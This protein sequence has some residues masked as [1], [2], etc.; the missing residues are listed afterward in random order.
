ML[1][2]RCIVS[3][4]RK[5]W[6]WLKHRF[7]D[8][9][10]DRTA[11]LY[12]AAFRDFVVVEV[13]R[14]IDRQPGFKP[15]PRRWVIER[16]LGWLIPWRRLVHD[17]EQKIENSEAF[18]HLALASL[19]LRRIAH[20]SILKQAL[21]SWQKSEKGTRRRPLRWPEQRPNPPSVTPSRTNEAPNTL[22]PRS[23]E[24][25]LEPHKIIAQDNAKQILYM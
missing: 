4:I 3:T 16:T 19:L 1:G 7:G 21:R 18:I 12:E 23:P 13:V 15:L 24:I 6:P 10:Y 17:Y 11:L 2:P 9:A 5:R 22:S 25:D 14:R 20:T 8:G